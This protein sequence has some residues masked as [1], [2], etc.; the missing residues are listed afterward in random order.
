MA[1]KIVNGNGNTMEDGD[2]SE[3]KIREQVRLRMEA[4]IQEELKKIALK[5]SFILIPRYFFHDF[6]TQPVFTF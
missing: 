3:Q 2:D 1:E 6:I 5:V 4:Q